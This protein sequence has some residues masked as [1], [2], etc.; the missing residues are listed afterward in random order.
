MPDI[1]PEIKFNLDTQEKFG[2]ARGVVFEHWS[3]IPSPIGL[4]DRG[5]YRR[6]DSLDTVSENGFIYKK[7]GCFVGTIIG[8]SHQNNSTVAEAGIFDNSTARIVIP[9]FYKDTEKSI[10]LLPGD[11]I[12]AK[13]IELGVENYQRAQYNPKS[14]DYLQFPAKCVSQLMDS[15]GISY[16]Q[17][18]NFTISEN[19]NIRWI[20]GKDNPGIDPETGKGRIYSI[21]YEYIAFWYIQQLINEIRITNNN[22][23]EDPARMPYHAAIQREYVYHNKNRGDK[24]ETNEKTETSRTNEEPK[25]SIEPNSPQVKVDIRNFSE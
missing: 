4:K 12:Y 23:A 8:N 19:G 13:D 24:A 25:E 3:A 21:R 18:K 1:I 10:S 15:K 20:A 2:N 5:D 7:V 16:E 22:G 17:G 9:R 11:R 14:S 6:P